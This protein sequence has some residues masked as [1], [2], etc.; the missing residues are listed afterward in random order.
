LPWNASSGAPRP[1]PK[2]LIVESSQYY[3]KSFTI[4]KKNPLHFCERHEIS[5]FMIT[6]NVMHGSGNIPK[7]E[8]LAGGV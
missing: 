3:S 1:R 6:S 8:V 2:R 4:R 7:I 5:H